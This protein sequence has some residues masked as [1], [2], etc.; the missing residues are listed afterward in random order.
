[1]CVCV[2]ADSAAEAAAARDALH[3]E[4]EQHRV[5]LPARPGGHRRP[6]HPRRLGAAAAHPVR[7]LPVRHRLLVAL[8]MGQGRNA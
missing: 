5:H 8:E 1:M 6:H 4:P 2:W 7:L 3:T